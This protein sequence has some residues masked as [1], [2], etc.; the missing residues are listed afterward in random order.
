MSSESRAFAVGLGVGAAVAAA[1]LLRRRS[2]TDADADAR[3]TWSSVG[4]LELNTSFALPKTLTTAPVAKEGGVTECTVK[5]VVCY[6]DSNTWG[7]DAFAQAE[8]DDEV[9][10]FRADPAT[11]TSAWNSSR[12]EK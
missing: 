8:D 1:V 12:Q 7:Y 10:G 9:A 11:T 5:R 2:S 4:T 6:G 3:H